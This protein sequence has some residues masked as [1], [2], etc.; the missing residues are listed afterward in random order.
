[1]FTDTSIKP[2]PGIVHA[3]ND[4]IKEKGAALLTCCARTCVL[5]NWIPDTTPSKTHRHRTVLE[6]VSLDFLT[7]KSHSGD[8]GFYEIWDPFMVNASLN[9]GAVFSRALV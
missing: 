4:K 2:C 3:A 9:I 7:C 6:Y 1:M 8:N 5:L